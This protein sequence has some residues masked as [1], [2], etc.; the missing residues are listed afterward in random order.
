M[1]PFYF[2]GYFEDEG[3]M[4]YLP[5]LASNMILSISASQVARITGVSHQ[6]LAKDRFLN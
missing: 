5:R 1:P 6:H 3:L 4:N 2:P